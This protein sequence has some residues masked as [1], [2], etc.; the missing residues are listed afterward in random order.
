M[1]YYAE[2][3]KTCIRIKANV[4]GRV[5]SERMI[6]T[7]ARRG[8]APRYAS[9]ELYIQAVLRQAGLTEYAPDG[10]DR[11]WIAFHVCSWEWQ[12]EKYLIDCISIVSGS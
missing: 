3:S 5:C 10:G 11:L 4:K 1:N 2:N 7:K 8:V 9:G 6:C 12:N